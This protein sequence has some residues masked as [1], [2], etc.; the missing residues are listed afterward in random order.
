MS[1]TRRRRTESRAPK[2]KRS[3]PNS[4]RMSREKSSLREERTSI[5]R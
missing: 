2:R 1:R 5:W 3:L 4:N